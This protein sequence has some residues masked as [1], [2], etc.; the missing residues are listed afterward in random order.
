MK[1]LIL[2][3]WLVP[4]LV[5]ALG[6]AGAQSL[7]DV[8]SSIQE[9][10]RAVQQSKQV[11]ACLP[12][13]AGSSVTIPG[14]QLIAWTGLIGVDF[15]TDQNLVPLGIEDRVALLN[16]AIVE[17][18]KVSAWYVNLRPGDLGNAAL[19]GAVRPYLREDFPELGRANATNYH[20][21]LL[22]LAQDV[23]RLRVLPW[24]FAS[25]KQSKDYS[26]RKWEE[27]IESEEE[28]GT[29][30]IVEK[31][32]EGTPAFTGWEPATLGQG[33]IPSGNSGSW[34][35]A[36]AGSSF[37]AAG[38]L[39]SASDHVTMSASFT[40]TGYEYQEETYSLREVAASKSTTFH[41]HAALFAQVPNR[42]GDQLG[43]KVAL[44]LRNSWSPAVSGDVS[45][46][47]SWDAGD[48]G[49]RVV[50]VAQDATEATTL[51]DDSQIT[52]NL[53]WFTGSSSD[54]TK[55]LKC[56]LPAGFTARKARLQGGSSSDWLGSYESDLEANQDRILARSL[57]AL[58]APNFVQGLDAGSKP[59]RLSQSES[60][61][62]PPSGDAAPVLNPVAGALVGIPLGVGLDG[63]SLG[64]I[65]VSPGEWRFNSLDVP[66]NYAG[67]ASG[68]LYPATFSG[69][70]GIRTDYASNLRFCGPA[71]DF[72][73]VYATSRA[74]SARGAP[75]PSAKPTAQQAVNSGIAQLMHA[76]D[77]PRLRQV[78]SRDLIA[79]IT[80]QGHYQ[81]TVK[82]YRRP[83]SAGVVNRT[84]GHL[85]IPDEQNLI[86]TLVFSNPSAG[87]GAYPPVGEQVQIV[88]GATTHLV[89][90]GSVGSFGWPN[91]LW[92]RT[93]V[94][95]TELFSK[96]VE[97]DWD[98]GYIQTNTT[99]ID[100]L[101]MAVDESVSDDW[102]DWWSYQAPDSLIRA[103]AGLTTYVTNTFD[104]SEGSQ[105][106][107]YPAMTV[108]DLPDRPDVEIDWKSSGVVDHVS[109]GPWSAS[110]TIDDNG[111]LKTET[112]FDESLIGTVWTEWSDGGMK[113]RTY[114]APD[115]SVTGKT[116]S[117]SDWSE[118][119]YGNATGTGYPG[120]PHKLTRKDD[121]GMTWGW[122]VNA[123][124]STAVETCDGL[125]VN[126]SVTRGIK[127]MA[128]A[129][130][131][132]YPTASESFVVQGGIEVK[133]AG[134]ATPTGQFSAWGAPLKA[135]DFV[136]GLTSSR[137]FDGRRERLASSTDALGLVTEYS[138]YDP[139]DRLTG[140]SW[141]GKAGTVAH[142]AGGFGIA[143]TLAIPNRPHSSSLTWDAMGRPLTSG[144]TAGGT[145]SQVFTRD[146]N[147]ETVAV[148]DDVTGATNSTGIR[149]A[150]GSVTSS[151]GTTLPFSGIGGSTLSVDESNGL[152]TSTRNLVELAAASRTTWSDSWGRTREA[153]TP[154]TS[155][156][157]A[158]D[159][160]VF[161]Y[162]VPAEKDDTSTPAAPMARVQTIAPSGR[163]FIEESV[164]YHSTGIVRRSGIDVNENGK[165]DATDRYVKSVTELAANKV[166]TIVSRNEDA[167]LRE[168][169]RSEWS[170]ADKKTV[171]T[172]NGS[173]E[174]ITREPHFDTIPKTVVVSST[175]GWTRTETL[176]LLGLSE[177]SILSG[178]GIPAAT[179][180]PTWRDDGSLGSVSLN[181]GGAVHSAT[182]NN[183]GTLA[184]LSVPGRGNILDGH[185]FAT[186]AGIR[187]EIMT[188][189]G[190]TRKRT[191]DGTEH[192]TSGDDVPAK[193]EALTTS[194]T[195]FKL[196]TSPTVGAAT[197]VAL[198][199]AGAPTA[200]NYA[201]DPATGLGILGETYF[202]GPGGLLASITLARGGSLAFGYSNNGAKDLTSAA[203]PTVASGVFTIP[204]LTHVFGHDRAGRVNEITD[205]ADTRI[206]GARTLVYQNGRLKE[207][208][209]NS[210]PLAGY[211]VVRSLDDSGRDTGFTLYRG[212]AVIHSAEKAPNGVSDQISALASGA[213]KVVPQRDA[214]GHVTGF[215][216][217]N[218]DGIF[219]PVVTQFWK[220]GPGGR[221]EEARTGEANN[222]ATNKV[223]GAPTFTYLIDPAK[224]DESFDTRGRRFKCATAGGTWT[225]AYTNGQLTSTT[226]PTLGS[227]SYQFDAI[228]R[229]LGKGPEE[230]DPNE[231]DLLNR[232]LAWTHT[233]DKTLKIQTAVGAGVHIEIGQ[234]TEDLTN[235]SGNGTRQVPIPG[236]DGGWVPWRVLAT[237]P[238][239]GEGAGSPP[240]NVLASPDAKAEQRGAVW[241]P[242]EDESFAYDAAGNRQNSALW[243]YGWDA[244]NQLVRARTKNCKNQATAQG[245][246]L[247]F[248]YD[249]EGRRFR[250]HVIRYQY[251]SIVSENHITFV[252]N[253]WDLLYERQQLPSGLTTLERKYLWG[254]DIADGQ[255]GGAGGLL[256]IRET[257]GDATKDIYPLYDGTGHVIALTNSDKELLAEYA[258][259]PFGE[260][261]HAKGPAAQA[262]PWRYATKYFD[263]ETG[264][265][266]F[267]KRYLDPITGQW[268]SREPL[269][270]S[271]SVNLYAYCHNDP[272][273]KVDV[274]G[275]HAMAI[276]NQDEANG[277][278]AEWLLTLLSVN[279]IPPFEPSAELTKFYSE[280]GNFG[281]TKPFESDDYKRAAEIYRRLM[282]NQ[283][284][285]R[286][287]D[288]TLA[289]ARLESLPMMRPGSLPIAEIRTLTLGGP[290]SP[291]LAQVN[292]SFLL[293]SGAAGFLLGNA[294]KG[295]Q[296]SKLLATGLSLERSSLIQGIN[297]EM[298]TGAVIGLMTA[299]RAPIG[300]G[301]LWNVINETIDPTVIRQF[302]P[303]SC[304]PACGQMLLRGQGIDAYQSGLALRQGSA[305]TPNA[306]GL[307]AA[308]NQ[309]GSVVWHGGFFDVFADPRRAFSLF[310]RKGSFATTL[311]SPGMQVSHMVVVDGLDNVGRVIIRDPAGT[312]SRYLMNW[313]DFFGIWQG[314]TIYQP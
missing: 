295:A 236:T 105:D 82:I 100:G 224:P 153:R 142:N 86:R 303:R 90:Q 163:K 40:T 59:S 79:D 247:T 43:G 219:V 124:G 30:T 178:T 223:P 265:Y 232:T 140:F 211:K 170:S 310:S 7:A 254:P 168:I 182:F 141:N 162:S 159:T 198:N 200:K 78:V 292:S 212:N 70:I 206:S 138:A 102:I 128:T 203:W 176:N 88:D 139:I 91:T 34:E 307:A 185:S 160:T 74:A 274:L 149:K 57:H 181:I 183:D 229:R 147:T 39:V 252:W 279:G 151:T 264:L 174:T 134:S 226:H 242:P 36:S 89:S 165:L 150:D 184:S 296:I 85:E 251:G 45:A 71:Q 121:T 250:K 136:T 137:S 17:F 9:R 33:A 238:N 241:V 49:Y 60:L 300:S 281:L 75:L 253:G 284:L 291:V 202:H 14:Q 1:V 69:P 191:L 196:T 218:S 193:S 18:R 13:V 207:T 26:I 204:A 268:L 171:I 275:L 107:R 127:S 50:A 24:P 114:A 47:A 313:D 260:L 255:A 92:F 240:A 20:A 172:V 113:V 205:Y 187:K 21:L 304:G 72:H 117:Q 220:R 235:F 73:V 84:P 302:N 3:R 299:K 231:S 148:S 215:Q 6:T 309:A 83:Q 233:Q 154:S 294:V 314:Q 35:Y 213:L 188:V 217:G 10:K 104:D 289:E 195:G 286:F 101:T 125:L 61:L 132:G 51:T 293:P 97:F 180:D 197:E 276:T 288:A 280:T 68:I 298:R 273:N 77:L 95:T 120:L 19:I 62:R 192:S 267:G 248:D 103:A 287:R 119:E 54:A 126:G 145:V 228:G 278:R 65:G 27:R 199:T 130:E 175:K 290:P 5:F 301:G 94:G 225:Y 297:S 155:G 306:D 16:Q 143:T 194:G 67:Y 158:K 99:A 42:T 167:G 112:L 271:E 46:P 201:V 272:I 66:Y 129:N 4:A 123:D 31:Y 237:L 259:G 269:G 312:G 96:S 189:D 109:Q 161:L 11:G 146:A 22:Q 44:L 179:L 152:L 210:G 58:C 283:G 93:T 108:I 282:Q 246:D 257:K 41:S 230:S 12:S 63:A 23:M 28:P 25:K 55:V 48:A 15:P 8:L 115:G 239:A 38:W 177:T 308:M 118:L 263:P 245:Y 135:L 249:A 76:W 221:I 266:Y 133:T 106:G 270:E 52:V 214:A 209:W 80:T 53:Q 258:Y 56:G 222:P 156:G 98:D 244:K 64:W 32:A 208:T 144:L 261:I 111:A 277:R 311:H 186:E 122:T 173:E 164:A 2:V 256:L 227:F 169:L 216:W 29:F 87:T 285:P 262:N 166:I 243:D 131:R 116:F 37:E 234:Q 305:L 110:C 81:N 157:T 190:V